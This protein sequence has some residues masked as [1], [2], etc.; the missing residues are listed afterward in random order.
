[1][2]LFNIFISINLLLALVAPQ[3]FSHPTGEA[4][5]EL[6]VGLAVLKDNADYHAARTAFVSVLEEKMDFHVHFKLLDAYGDLESYQKGLKR[7]VEEDK[8]DL[9][10][11]TGTRSTIP[12][13][14]YSSK[15]P[16]VFSAV[17]AP[18]KA[19]V[20]KSLARR[21]ENVTGT[22]CEVPAYAQLKTILKIF[23]FVR[24]LG[25]VYTRDE[26]N[27]EI[28]LQ[29]FQ[30]AAKELNLNI[31]TASVSP[32]CRSEHE[33]AQ[34]TK[35]IVDK[36]EVLIAL[37]DTSLA[38]Y[39][40]GMVDIGL[41]S[42]IPTYTSL[43]HLLSAGALISLGMDFKNIGAMAGEKAYKILK[44]SVPPGHMPITVDQKYL[45][46]INLNAAHK[47]GITIPIQV[48]RTASRIIK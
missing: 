8:V 44:S 4:S 39:G 11:T 2:K 35:K 48:L 28:Q 7:F 46:V 24:T 37:Q 31:L 41:R 19:G 33:V 16:I 22:H 17:A 15:V 30:A 42:S 18:V 36:V 40:K 38:R 14:Q 27:A 43:T 13:I 3:S 6:T 32:D 26:P 45:L 12:A 34:A 9:I 10:F 1:M 25:I 47:M 5:P 21:E 20:V 29:D 23:P